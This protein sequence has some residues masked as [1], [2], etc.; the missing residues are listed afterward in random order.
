MEQTDF[1]EKKTHGNFQN[2]NSL[3]CFYLSLSLF[4]YTVET[5]LERSLWSNF[6]VKIF[7]RQIFTLQSNIIPQF[8]QEMELLQRKFVQFIFH[9]PYRRLGDITDRFPGWLQLRCCLS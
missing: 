7:L 2:A 9:F 6:F 3:H 1:D 5:P 4:T 8:V